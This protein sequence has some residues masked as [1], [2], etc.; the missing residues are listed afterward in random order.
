MTTEKLKYLVPSGPRPA[1]ARVLCGI[2]G[3]R[4]AFEA[5]RQAIR[6]AEPGGSV[7]FMAVTDSRGVGPNE[8]A[9]FS[10]RRAHDALAKVRR[11]AAGAQVEATSVILSSEHPSRVLLEAAAEHDLLCVASHR[12]SRPGGI[13]LG[14]TTTAAVHGSPVSVLVA[15]EP[16]Y[17]SGFPGPV[18][19]ATDGSEWAARAAR[20]GSRVAS[21]CDCDVLLL[22]VE[23]DAAYSRPA[24]A[25]DAV[26]VISQ[27]GKE[28]VVIVERGAAHRVIPEVALRE[29][30]GLVVV[31]SRGLRALAA[32]GSVS[33]R[34]AHE[35]Y[36]SVLVVRREHNDR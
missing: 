26:E 11:M 14:S 30:A 3:S 20:A 4:S 9:T 6:L 18:L 34:V 17:G 36:C 29:R 1:Y 28:P 23:G 21:A 10:A 8:T 22:V 19:I 5:A 32:L 13:L 15:R 33:E 35:A 2:D 16:R 12:F 31:G 27:L 24:I 25:H 7:V